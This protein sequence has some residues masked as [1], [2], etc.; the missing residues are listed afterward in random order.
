MALYSPLSPLP[1]SSDVH[2][3]CAYRMCLFDVEQAALDLFS[4]T[5][6]LA[7]RSVAI[8]HPFNTTIRAQLHAS[9]RLAWGGW[10]DSLFPA[11]VRGR[12]CGVMLMNAH[13]SNTRV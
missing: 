5:R 4:W 3:G 8:I 7:G 11:G 2:I 13:P 1:T 12:G 6:A 9:A 10:A